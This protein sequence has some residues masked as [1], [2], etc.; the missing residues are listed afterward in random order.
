[1]LILK[2]S[3]ITASTLCC[4]EPEEKFQKRVREDRNMNP[5][6]LSKSGNGQER[7]NVTVIKIGADEDPL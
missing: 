3:V 4:F 2:V 1:M 7:Q 5:S 6:K